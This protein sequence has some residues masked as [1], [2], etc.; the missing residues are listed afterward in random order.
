[1]NKKIKIF[2][3]IFTLQL[4]FACH[5]SIKDGTTDTI[6]IY[7][8]CGMCEKT[9]EKAGN[10]NGVAQVDWNKDT[11]MAVVTYDANKTNKEEILKRIALAGYDSDNHVAPDDVYAKLPSCCQYDR[12]NKSVTANTEIENDKLENNGTSIIDSTVLDKKDD[13][14]THKQ[15]S[16]VLKVENSK[17]TTTENNSKPSQKI[18]SNSTKKKMEINEKQTSR[19]QAS[20]KPLIV[21]KEN[22]LKKVFDNYFALKDA[23]VKTDGNIA[24]TKAKNILSAIN[25]VAMDKLATEE[26]TVWMKVMKDL[27]FDAEH[28][29]ETKDVDHQR[30][31]FNTFSDNIYQLM[32][33]SKLESPTYFQ[34]C[35]MAN[36]GKGANWLS[37]ENAVKNPYYG[38]EML[39]CGKT[40][41]TLK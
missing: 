19:N 32:K 36:D 11:K 39:T 13:H 29:E 7:G 2:S 4:F 12:P 17:E 9:I 25:A 30:S 22:Q 31:H 16:E 38:N 20:E 8:N 10:V 28:I 27:K 33:V 3:A 23:L 5:S 26:H 15:Q 35:P 41:E 6:K 18:V 21:V 24:S 34:H 14:S 37:K 40:V 1:M